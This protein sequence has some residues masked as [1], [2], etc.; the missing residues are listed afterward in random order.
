MDP[1]FG[2]VPPRPGFKSPLGHIR[3]ALTCGFMNYALK[4]ATEPQ[5]R[6]MGVQLPRGVLSLTNPITP[7]VLC[8]GPQGDRLYQAAPKHWPSRA[9]L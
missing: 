6:G 7:T 5:V 4:I 3:L 8:D 1:P 2:D 9:W